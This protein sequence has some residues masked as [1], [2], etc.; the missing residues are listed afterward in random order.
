MH[1]TLYSLC[2]QQT[3][4]YLFIDCEILNQLGDIKRVSKMAKNKSDFTR[5]YICYFVVIFYVQHLVSRCNKL[6]QNQALTIEIII[7]STLF[8]P[9]SKVED[10]AKQYL[11]FC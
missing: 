2:N 6:Y 11:L 7:N 1:H 9:T 3:E 10:S 8:R 5:V 4:S